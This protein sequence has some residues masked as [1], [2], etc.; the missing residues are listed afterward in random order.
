MHARVKPNRVQ[1]AVSKPAQ[2]LRGAAQ[3][4]ALRFVP[5]VTGPNLRL[6]MSVNGLC[7]FESIGSS[8]RDHVERVNLGLS[9]NP[10]S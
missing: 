8:P 5:R 10:L 4:A 3:A 2:P 7:H 1:L 9:S 6:S